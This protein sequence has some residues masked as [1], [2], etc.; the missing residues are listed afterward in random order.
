MKVTLFKRIGGIEFDINTSSEQGILFHFLISNYG[1][2]YKQIK[3]SGMIL[4]R[5]EPDTEVSHLIVS[6]INS[7][8][9]EFIVAYD[10]AE[11]TESLNNQ[12]N[13]ATVDYNNSGDFMALE[14][15][16]YLLSTVEIGG[17]TVIAKFPSSMFQRNATMKTDDFYVGLCVYPEIIGDWDEEGCMRHTYHMR[18]KQIEDD[19]FYSL[20]FKNPINSEVYTV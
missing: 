18:F 1:S 17:R 4:T 8:N 19:V 20:D 7:N 10:R 14:F 13:G 15:K 3:L 11:E 9:A 6:F 12:M 2:M 16:G 5:V